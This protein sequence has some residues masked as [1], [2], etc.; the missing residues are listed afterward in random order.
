MTLSALAEIFRFILCDKT[1][2]IKLFTSNFEGEYLF[3]KRALALL[4]AK[5]AIL[6]LGLG[7]Q[8]I[9]SLTDL[10][11]EVSGLVS[12]IKFNIYFTT[13]SPTGIF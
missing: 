3:S 13:L 7:P 9:L 6:A 8:R 11:L 4:A 1:G 12:F 5:S 2:L 10:I